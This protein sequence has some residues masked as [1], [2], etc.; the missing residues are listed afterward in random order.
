MAETTIT[1]KIE[2]HSEGTRVTVNA[3]VEHDF[4]QL[5][6]AMGYANWAVVDSNR[7]HTNSV[8]L[9]AGDWLP[10]PVFVDN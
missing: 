10:T 8:N 2:D 3:S 5:Y 6:S 1:I 4:Q 9:T 7:D